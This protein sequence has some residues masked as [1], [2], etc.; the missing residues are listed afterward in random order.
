MHLRAVTFLQ[1]CP[2]AFNPNRQGVDFLLF[3]LLMSTSIVWKTK[4][5]VLDDLSLTSTML[6]AL[7]LSKSVIKTNQSIEQ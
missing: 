2:S 3:Q 1:P 5:L 6:H 7:S 4:D